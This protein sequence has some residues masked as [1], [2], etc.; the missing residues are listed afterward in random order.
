MISYSESLFW[1]L[2]LDFV[3]GV[4][5]LFHHVLFIALNQLNVIDK[6]VIK[7]KFWQK[8]FKL[9]KKVWVVH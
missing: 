8:C 5:L 7:Y 2:L 6:I 9:I 4:P 3:G 1:F